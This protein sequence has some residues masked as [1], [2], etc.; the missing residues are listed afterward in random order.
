MWL[1]GNLIHHHISTS[2]S[3]HSSIL[4]I[5]YRVQHVP[6]SSRCRSQET[7]RYLPSLSNQERYYHRSQ[8]GSNVWPL[9]ADWTEQNSSSYFH[10]LYKPKNEQCNV[11]LLLFINERW[12]SVGQIL[13]CFHCM[14]HRDRENISGLKHKYVFRYEPELLPIVPLSRVETSLEHDCAVINHRICVHRQRRDYHCKE[15]NLPHVTASNQKT[16]PFC[17]IWFRTHSVSYLLFYVVYHRLFYT[18]CAEPSQTCVCRSKPCTGNH[19]W[20]YSILWRTQYV[21]T[22][23]PLRK[24][25]LNWRMHRSFLYQISLHRK[26]HKVIN[27]PGNRRV[28]H[29]AACFP[30]IT[31]Y[32]LNHLF[33]WIMIWMKI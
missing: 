2:L 16:T 25:P 10:F 15:N 13:I 27:I 4:I 6:R 20:T 8:I 18:K 9:P 19:N 5:R 26:Q 11:Q 31:A 12:N 33:R 21:I 30:K 3:I 17:G 22:T 14:L 23:F 32:S 1:K 29:W 28:S 7:I 24:R